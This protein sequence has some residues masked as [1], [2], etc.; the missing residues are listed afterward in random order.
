MSYSLKGFDSSISFILQYF[1]IFIIIQLLYTIINT[2]FSIIHIFK[3]FFTKKGIKFL[4][5]YKLIG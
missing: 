2:C 4:Y 1:N 5:T 3:A